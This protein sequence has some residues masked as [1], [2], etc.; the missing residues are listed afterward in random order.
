MWQQPIVDRTRQDVALG[1]EKG[2]CNAADLARL[3]NNCAQLA[4]QLGMTLQLRTGGWSATDLPTYSE[5]DR[6]VK[7]LALLAGYRPY[8][9]TPPPP[10]SPLNHWEKWNAAEQI[11]LDV[12][13]NYADNQA[14]RSYCGEAVAGE[15]TEIL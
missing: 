13:R 1:R 6:I 9:S 5:L 4:Q 3:D 7:N 15:R 2:Y 10:Q 8:T 12:H 14:A 11:L